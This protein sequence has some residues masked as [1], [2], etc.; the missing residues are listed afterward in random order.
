MGSF[1]TSRHCA[2][3]VP[4]LKT[5]LD[6]SHQIRFQHFIGNADHVLKCSGV[7]DTMTYDNRL[8]YP[9]NG[10]AAILFEVE[11]IKMFVVDVAVLNDV[12]NTFSKFENYIAGET[13]AN[14]Y[15]GFCG[16]DIAAFNIA[17]KI[18]LLV[19]F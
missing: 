8:G 13:L 4:L 2:F 5:L 11:A 10:Y 12:V 3:T 14:K 18:D 1:G 15:I 9:K 19:F 16:E 6:L 7:G 17:D